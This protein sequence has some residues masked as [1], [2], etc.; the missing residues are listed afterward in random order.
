MLKSTTNPSPGTQNLFK[1]IIVELTCVLVLAS[2]PSG[3]GVLEHLLY[4]FSVPPPSGVNC[5]PISSLQEVPQR[6]GQVN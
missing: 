5:N 1:E 6:H 4:S 2:I 3:L